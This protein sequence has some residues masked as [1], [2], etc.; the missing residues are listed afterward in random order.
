MYPF[1]TTFAENI[2]NAKYSNGLNWKEKVEVLVREVCDGIMPVKEMDELS[3]Y[4][5]EMKFIPAGRY[6]YY[7]GQKANFYNNCF[8]L[9]AEEDTREEWA[10]L[11]SNAM[12]CLMVGGGIGIDYSKLRPSGSKLSRTSGTASGPVPLMKV[13]NEV[14]RN[15]MQGGTRRSAMYA[16][17]DWSHA[18]VM[19]FIYAKNWSD[20]VR[21]MKAKD[22]NFPADL[23]MTNISVNYDDNFLRLLKE[24]NQTAKEVWDANI[25]Q[26]LMTAEPGMSFNFGVNSGD[27]LRN[28]CTEFTSSDDSDVC[29]LGSVNFGNIQH[30]GEL[31]RVSY[32]ASKFLV[33]GGYRA[34][35]PYEKVAK[36]REKNR[37]IGL[38]LMGLHE[39][40]L[41]KGYRYE[42]NSELIEWLDIWRDSNEY[43]ANIVSDELGINHPKKY[44]AIAPTGTIGILASTTTGIEP[45]Y[46]V[47]YKRRYLM[48]PSRWKFEYVIDATAEQLIN[49]YGLRPD[50]IETSSSLASDP[51][52]RIKFQWEVQKFVDMAISSTINLPRYEDQTFTKE[53]FSDIVLKYA[54]GLRGLTV[55][56]DGS[57]GGQPLTTVPYDEAKGSIGVV[58]D[59]TEEKCSGGV[60]GL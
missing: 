54:E 1:K 13:M 40:L 36:V 52:R 55:Y 10:R 33:C 31:A 8:C 2:Y 58:F 32:L 38:G 16:S 18:D 9:G 12:A 53:Q 30:P 42:M 24:G 3:K 34:E 60:C 23:D 57:R 56:P 37:K 6:L 50:D 5:Y 25:S 49:K 47:S 21:E 45:L 29:N 15:V 27:T 26:M 14:G 46:A 43:G 41:R 4:I 20:K 19:Q 59:E 11:T 7:A 22:F 39:W 51:E 17:L 48:G 28:A 35:L 44:R